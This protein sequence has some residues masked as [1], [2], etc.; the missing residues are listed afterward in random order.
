M[1]AAGPRGPGR[2]EGGGFAAAHSRCAARP[3]PG[4]APRKG[5]VAAPPASRLLRTALRAA[6]LRAGLDPGDHCG[7]AGRKYGQAPAC[8]A[9]S[10]ARPRAGDTHSLPDQGEAL[11]LTRREVEG[12]DVRVAR[13]EAKITR[14]RYEDLSTVSGE[15][16]LARLE[17]LGTAALEADPRWNR[18][19][20]RPAD[21]P[22]TGTT[23]SI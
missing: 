17:A 5:Y 16:R 23:T 8:P 18:E 20:R 14:N 2:K 9:R 10:T 3:R 22:T 19:P 4:N 11:L 12:T 1:T 15:P 21:T 13:T 7:P 6:A